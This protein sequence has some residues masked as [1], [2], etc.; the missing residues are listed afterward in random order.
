MEVI[1]RIESS[2]DGFSYDVVF[3]HRPIT[4]KDALAEI[5]MWR[6]ENPI[7]GAYATYVNDAVAESTWLDSEYKKQ[8]DGSVD[9]AI[10]GTCYGGGGYYCGIDIRIN[11]EKLTYVNEKPLKMCTFNY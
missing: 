8:Y 9:D 2:R 4:V 10:V 7:K 11:T 6:E 5:S 1:Q 3:S